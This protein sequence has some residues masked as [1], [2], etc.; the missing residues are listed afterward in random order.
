ML[1]FSFPMVAVSIGFAVRKEVNT[2]KATQGQNYER[3]H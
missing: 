1:C 2:D 3:F